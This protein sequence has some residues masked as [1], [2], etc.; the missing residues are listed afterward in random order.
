M[1][2]LFISFLVF[3]SVAALAAEDMRF[4]FN[5]KDSMGLGFVKKEKDDKSLQLYVWTDLHMS[6]I[7]RA[8]V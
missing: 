7:G 1:K 8:H 6:K 4:C 2:A 5:D 3:G